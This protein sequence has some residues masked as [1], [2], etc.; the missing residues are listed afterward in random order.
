MALEGL[1]K[2]LFGFEFCQA[3]Q[4]GAVAGGSLDCSEEQAPDFPWFS[5]LA[6]FP[7]HFF[8]FATF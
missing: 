3:F 5:Q 6:T 8:Q 1:F 7:K 2:V 4:F